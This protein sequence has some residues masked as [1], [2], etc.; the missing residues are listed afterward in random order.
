MDEVEHMYEQAI[1]NATARGDND[2]A[3]DLSIGLRE[4]LE[5]YKS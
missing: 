2:R 3:H 5:R 4:Y 1:A